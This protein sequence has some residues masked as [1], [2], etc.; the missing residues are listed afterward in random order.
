MTVRRPRGLRGLIVAL[1][2][3]VLVLPA[4]LANADPV[5]PGTWVSGEWARV[6]LTSIAPQKTKYQVGDVLNLSYRI[7]ANLSEI[8]NISV[9][10]DSVVNANACNWRNL[11]AGPGGKYN[12]GRNTTYTITEQDLQQGFAK[13]S[14]T[15]TASGTATGTIYPS[16]TIENQV[17]VGDPE[18]IVWPELEDGVSRVL[19]N[20]G[21]FGFTCHRIPALTVSPKNG[22]LLAAW[23]GRPNNC[24]DAPNP[25]HII[26]RVSK[27]GGKSWEEPTTIAAGQG[28][29]AKFGYS[30][31]SYVV[32]HDQDKIFAFFVKSYDQSFQG[33]G[34]GTDPQQRNVLHAVVVESTDDGVSWSQPRVITG[35][36]VPNG[37]T[38]LWRSRF[39]ASGEGIQ[40]RYG[41]KAGRLVQQFTFAKVGGGYYAASV[42]SDDHGQT[43]H[44][45]SPIGPGMD[46]NKVVEL[47]DGTLMMNSRRSSG[48]GGRWVAY[49]K[50]QGQ[51]W[52]DLHV[53]QSLVDP[54]NNASII[55]AF[56]NAAQGSED[57]KVLLF[58]NSFSAS[59]RRNGAVRV[60]LDDGKTWSQHKV[61]APGEMAYSTL[62]PL[63]QQGKY[64]LLFEGPGPRIEYMPVSLDWLKLLRVQIG[65]EL[66]TVRRGE[67]SVSFTV[68]NK[69]SKAAVGS[70]EFSVPAG[71]SVSGPVDINV[72]AGQTKTYQVSV[73]APSAADPA[74][75]VL[76]AQGTFG[77][78]AVTG[79]VPVELQLRPGQSAS[80][81]LDVELVNDLPFQGG[82]N[83]EPPSKMFDDDL[84]SMWH[85]PWNTSVRL[86]LNI[87][88]KLGEEPQDLGF[89]MH[90]PRRTG[91]DN[92]RIADY[93]IL[94]G[95][96]LAN[97]RPV[98][99]GRW[100][101]S[102]AQQFVD[103]VGHKSKYLRLTIKD[104]YN[105]QPGMKFASVAELAVHALVADSGDSVGSFVD[106][107]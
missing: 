62:T 3:L 96:D 29:P 54:V 5:D 21:D 49:S 70:V 55:R 82:Q 91:G 36:I 46:E 52:T 47:S 38:N 37:E 31:P 68:T 19:A 30:D 71:W 74:T 51:T 80:R 86:P 65:H 90:A 60:S 95:D 77:D 99:E 92:G 44:V 106:C 93:Q 81:K 79:E 41:P 97:L 13:F 1:L 107:A 14:V 43:W 104:T 72:S 105:S 98:A 103:L 32:D 20:P 18:P 64:G 84:D 50:D 75:H 12:C 40:L 100:P 101:N 7:E 66:Q 9:V 35:D 59:G 78:V 61:F 89:L 6:R 69:G 11:P 15:W 67:N 27:D 28:G 88:L 58:S 73:T 24:G 26:Q 33:S 25:N 16:I 85:S 8:S 48:G 57:A 23:D 94:V 76:V 83:A 34:V 4:G 10:S 2:A 53:D 102:S 39:A 22:W 87:D 63:N 45:G 17:A 56:P 42:F